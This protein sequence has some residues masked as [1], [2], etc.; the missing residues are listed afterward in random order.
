M[1]TFIKGFKGRRERKRAK[2]LKSVSYEMASL[3]KLWEVGDMTQSSFRCKPERERGFKMRWQFNRVFYYGDK[4]RLSQFKW[5]IEIIVTHK[6]D[7]FFQHKKKGR[8]EACRESDLVSNKDD[9]SRDKYKRNF[10]LLLLIFFL[11][12]F[13]CPENHVC[14][15]MHL[16]VAVGKTALES[17]VV[18]KG[19]QRIWSA[20]QQEKEV[21]KFWH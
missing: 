5:R 19:R 3:N 14:Q 11:I 17:I 20:A 1:V 16:A 4:H 12:N 9:L 2:P 8:K 21:T 6:L 13:S 18:M 10:F 15:N 7:K